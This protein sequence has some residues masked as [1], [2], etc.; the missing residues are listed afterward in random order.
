MALSLCVLV[1]TATVVACA[2]SAVLP[3]LSEGDVCRLGD[4]RRGLCKPLSQCSPAIQ[5]LRQERIKPIHCSFK[6]FE[7]VVC[8]DDE[9]SQRLRKSELACREYVNEL[10]LR[11]N[12]FIKGSQDAELG[13]YP[14]MAALG[15]VDPSEPSQVDWNCGGSLI[16][17]RYV[18]TAA[19]CVVPTSRT[20]PPV[21]V[22]LGAVD[23]NEPGFLAQKYHV[24]KW[25]QHPEYSTATVYND[26][27][28]I[29]LDRTVKFSENIQ[30]A[31]LYTKS[32]IPDLGLEVTGW[33]LTSNK[34]SSK[35]PILQ[36][37]TLSLVPNDKCN[38][39]YV[40]VRR[41][42]RGVQDTMLCAG[43][44]QG[45]MDTCNGD[46]GGPL[47]VKTTE[48][49]AYSIVGVTS[50]GPLCG[51]STPGIYTRV[52]KYVDWVESV[53]WN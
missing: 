53:V 38:E 10:P 15:Y 25:I 41:V 52:N 28:L 7:E 34:R 24:K 11:V 20:K 49:N 8:C 2:M 40:S 48:N 19:H 17:D 16:S 5:K 42:N 37:A 43:D 29:E 45:I 6:G 12:P 46:S 50:F 44:P 13:D 47:Q 1:L 18:L 39:S 22:L 14:H 23:L 26:I 31:C 3:V 36:Y 33:G 35:S 32:D 4:G 9:F 30:P 21:T 51:G 27:A